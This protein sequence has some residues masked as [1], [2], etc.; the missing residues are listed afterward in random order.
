MHDGPTFRPL[1]EPLALAAVEIA[2]L[3]GLADGL[4]GVIARL[5]AQAGCAD[6]ELLSEAQA[7]D[8]LSQ[9]LTGMAAFLSALASAAPEGV[10]TDVQA[11]VIDLTVAEQARR[12]SGPPPAVAAQTLLALSGDV[13]LFGD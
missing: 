8:L 2:D 13:T 11:A 6:A 7:A 4:Q 3:A 9:R 5:A 10:T 12:L 1:G